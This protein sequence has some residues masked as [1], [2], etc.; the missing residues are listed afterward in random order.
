MV[1]PELSPVGESLMAA[2][3]RNYVSSLLGAPLPIT[4]TFGNVRKIF[5]TNPIIEILT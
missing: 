4:L 2:P 5:L 3:S 1:S